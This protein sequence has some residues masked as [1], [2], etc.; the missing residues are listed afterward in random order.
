MLE[1]LTDNLSKIFNK[2]FVGGILT[3]EQID[4]AMREVRIALLEA[5]VALPVIKAF[6]AKV[7]EKATGQE[8]LRSVTPKQMVIKIIHD[9][10]V[11][12]LGGNDAVSIVLNKKPAN[13]MMVGLQGSGKTT[14]S[15]KLA[16]YL[17]KQNKKVLLVSLDVYR[18][19]AQEQ[20]QKLAELAKI[21]SLCIDMKE[22]PLEI[23]KRALDEA[24][25]HRYDVVIFDTAGRLHID[26]VMQQELKDI[27][28]LTNPS[29]ILLT[30]DALTG[31]DAVN[32]AI[33]FQKSL[34][35]TG[36]IL[37]RV[38]GDSR[39]GAALSV[40]YVTGKSIKFVGLGEKLEAFDVFHPDRFASRILD[41]G[42]VVS[43]VEK[44]TET[45]DQED[46]EKMAKKLQKGQFTLDDYL[47]Q[48]KGLKKL[49]GI[50]KVLGFLPGM[51]QMKEK[52]QQTNIDEKMFLRQEAIILSMTKGE[53]KNPKILNFSRKR[54]ITSGSG[55]SV[56]ELNRLLKQ[57]LQMNSMMKKMDPKLMLRNNKFI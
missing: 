52:I 24:L 39:G 5:D 44:A 43:L 27:K 11:A 4:L 18:P 31:Q 36:V 41:M 38:D 8:V 37:T 48:L 20:L 49:G 23:T 42:D 32:V 6:V 2:L 15:V 17:E 16:L 29:E 13:I 7:K 50:S 47:S 26:E 45:I 30:A 54:R 3:E 14:S 10:L 35:L 19:A 21:D 51:G 9:E 25:L 33:N 28:F 40:K 56:Q 1:S 46:A 34:D 55:T 57:F 12:I 22:Q 53:R